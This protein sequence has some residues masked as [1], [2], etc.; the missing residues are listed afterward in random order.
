MIM[1]ILTHKSIIFQI[2]LSFFGI[3]FFVSCTNDEKSTISKNEPTEFLNST[4]DT[5]LLLGSR[6]D[7]SKSALNFTILDN[8]IA[9]SDNMETLLYKTWTVK[10]NQITFIIES[11]GNGTSS[12]DSVTYDIDKLTDDELILRQGTNLSG[13]MKSKR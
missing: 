12:T 4:V 6:K 3:L 10:G 9:R 2:F 11:I 8:G 13:Y 5:T 1:K 7:T